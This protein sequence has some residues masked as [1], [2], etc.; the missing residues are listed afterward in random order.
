MSPP[1]V[2][3]PSESSHTARRPSIDLWY[4][5][6]Q[7]FGHLGNPQWF[8]NVLGRR[9]VWLDSEGCST[10]GGDIEAVHVAAVEGFLRLEDDL[11]G[12]K[13][14]ALDAQDRDGAVDAEGAELLWLEDSGA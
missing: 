9:A 12:K 8:D 13:R 11:L 10:S 2:E 4:G 14:D 3:Q 7:L 1:L 5:P 6:K